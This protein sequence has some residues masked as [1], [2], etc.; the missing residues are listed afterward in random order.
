MLYTYLDIRW[1]GYGEKQRKTVI[2]KKNKKN[3]IKMTSESNFRAAAVDN[4]AG[5]G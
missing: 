2:N 5:I 1:E 4:G 3:A